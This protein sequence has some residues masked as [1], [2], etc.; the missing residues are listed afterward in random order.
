M[1]TAYYG[2]SEIRLDN[3]D[4]PRLLHACMLHQGGV[5]VT[6]GKVLEKL[7]K[8]RDAISY[9]CL[10]VYL[11]GVCHLTGMCGPQNE[12]LYNLALGDAIA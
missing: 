6:G 12:N 11:Q 1:Q 4:P 2:D 9:S 3:M 7:P 8:L 10:E 5:L